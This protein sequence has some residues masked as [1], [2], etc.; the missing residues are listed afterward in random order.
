MEDRRNEWGIGRMRQVRET[1]AK[2]NEGMQEEE[3]IGGGGRRSWKKG[4]TVGTKARMSW[5]G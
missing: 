4:N 5:L 2:R 3:G 1:R